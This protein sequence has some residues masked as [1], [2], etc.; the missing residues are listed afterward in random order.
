MAARPVTAGQFGELDADR[1]GTVAASGYDVAW[2]IPSTDQYTVWSTD[3]N[4]N[5]ISNL[6]PDVVRETAPRWKLL[7]TTFHQD[8]NGD[9]TTGVPPALASHAAVQSDSAVI[10]EAGSD[11]FVFRPDLGAAST[12][13]SA[14]KFELA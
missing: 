9:R 4:G 2:K 6:I 10:A 3:S 7:E 11:N 8:L 14:D 12:V 1:R 13:T 5:F